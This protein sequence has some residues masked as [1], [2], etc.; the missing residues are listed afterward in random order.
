MV[1][2]KNLR[3]V[4]HQWG[5]ATAY[6][7]ASTHLIHDLCAGLLV[8]LL[9]FIREGFGLNY[10]Q[11]GILLSV[12]SITSGLSQILGGWL[13]DRFS[14]RIV[15]AVGLAGVGLTGLA[16]GLNSTYYLLLFIFVVMGIFRGAYHPSAVSMLSG[17]FEEARR[18]K[19]IA[20]H[21]VG[22]SIGFTMGPLLGGLIAQTLGWRF[23]FIILSIPLL[24]AVPLVLKKLKRLERVDGVE[25][26]G[27]VFSTADA[28]AKPVQGWSGIGQVLRAVALVTVLAVLIQWITGLARSFLPVYLVDKYNINPAHAAMLIS[29]IRG[30][31]VA[32]GLFGGWLADKWGRKNAFSLA[33][34]ATGPILY[35]LTILPFNIVL[36]VI[37]VLFGLVMAMRQ[38]IIQALL[39]DSS[40]PQ[41]RATVFGIYFGLSMEGAS[42]LQPVAGHFMDIFGIIDVFHVIALASIALSLMGL[43]LIKRSKLRG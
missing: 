29:I 21:M 9:P 27:H 10:L 34:I 22:G 39:M 41:L 36:M 15:L 18:G 38:V 7:F 5:G 32:G 43:I 13:G 12:Y 23:A 31:G 24:V 40:P 17:Q 1:E 20:L 6:F 35:L 11:S 14:R 2:F 28:A 8:V 26:V 4:S 33:L 3:N 19:V 42:L 25:P 16:V 37:F 30:G